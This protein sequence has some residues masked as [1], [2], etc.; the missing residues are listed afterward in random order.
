M[1]L[2][3]SRALQHTATF[4][5]GIKSPQTSPNPQ[6]AH[7]WFPEGAYPVTLLWGCAL[8][9]MALAQQNKS[10]LHCSKLHHVKGGFH[11]SWVGIILEESYKATD[12]CQ[13][14]DLFVNRMEQKQS[15]MFSHK[16]R[17]CSTYR[18]CTVETER[19]N[20]ER[21]C[22]ETARPFAVLVLRILGDFDC[23]A[24]S[25]YVKQSS[26]LFDSCAP[27]WDCARKRET[28]L[29]TSETVLCVLSTRVEHN[30]GLL[31][32]L[33]ESPQWVQKALA[34]KCNKAMK[35]MVISFALQDLG[36]LSRAARWAWRMVAVETLASL[37]EGLGLIRSSLCAFA[38]GVLQLFMCLYSSKRV[39]RRV[40]QGP[41]MILHVPCL[42]LQKMLCFPSLC[43]Q[44]RDRPFQGV[45]VCCG[46]VRKELLSDSR[47][48]IW[49]WRLTLWDFD[50]FLPWRQ[51]TLSLCSW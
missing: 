13:L 19:K 48:Q 34:I 24:M 33:A 15:A 12:T 10:R 7:G 26:G 14:L 46:S 5:L 8:P 18:Y 38:V 50:D 6:V 9:L 11:L 37:A 23:S 35:A 47:Q 44:N 36:L 45:I 30:R 39:E 43:F 32:F 2:L 49:P 17:T 31:D 20:P 42:L 25:Y 21:D 16:K 29:H 51:N 22:Q 4:I 41:V 28:T 27:R 1:Q 40:W 3:H